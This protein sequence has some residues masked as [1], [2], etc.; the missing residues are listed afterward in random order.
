MGSPAGAAE[1]LAADPAGAPSL[2]AV[3]GFNGKVAG[4]GGAADSRALYGGAGS[5]AVPLGFR[6]GLQIDAWPP[7][8]TAGFRGASP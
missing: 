7:G 3:D 5:L 4:F 8:S 2:P 6:Y 1:L